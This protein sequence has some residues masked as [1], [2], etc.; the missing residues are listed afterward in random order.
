MDTALRTIFDDVY[1]YVVRNK[2]FPD[3]T[4]SRKMVENVLEEFDYNPNK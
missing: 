4:D 2:Y 1:L 3:V